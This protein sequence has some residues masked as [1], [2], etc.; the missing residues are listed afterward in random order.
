MIQKIRPIRLFIII[1]CLLT[2]KA[3]AD[4]GACC[5]NSGACY[6]TTSALVCSIHGGIWHPNLTCDDVTCETNCDGGDCSLGEVLDCNGHC[7]PISWIGDGNCDNG[8]RQWDSNTIYLDCEE[9]GY[10]GGDCSPPTDLPINPGACCIG[11]LSECDPRVCENL[12]YSSCISSNGQFLGENTAC[13]TEICS[14]P[15]GQ[16]GDCNGN[17]FPLYYLNDGICHDGHWFP[18]N[19]EDFNEYQLNL[20]CIELA[21]DYGDCTGVC[22][23][24]CCIGQNC[25]DGLPYTQCAEQGGTFLGSGETCESIDCSSY[26]ISQSVGVELIG[27]ESPIDGEFANT[28]AASDGIFI[29]ALS[30]A[31]NTNTGQPVTAA[32]VYRGNSILSQTLY[33]PVGWVSQSTCVDTD[34]ARIL[35]GQGYELRVYVDNGSTFILEQIL[36]LGSA[37]TNLSISDDVIFATTSDSNEGNGV[38]WFKRSGS[39]WIEQKP[40]LLET[41]VKN[42]VIDGDSIAL[43]TYGSLKMYS[44]DGTS[45]IE[46]D[47]DS[48]SIQ[49]NWQDVDI[50]GIYVVLGETTN[51]YNGIVAQARVFKKAEL[52]WLLDAN[53]IPV[54]TRPDDEYGYSVSIENGVACISGCF[55]DSSILNGGMIAVYKNLGGNWTYVSKAVPYNP[56]PTMGFGRAIATDG[57][58]IISTW[59]TITQD[60]W[61]FGETGSQ[62]IRLPD[63][64]WSNSDGGVIDSQ[65]NWIPSLPSEGEAVSVS[66]PARFE[67]SIPNAFPFSH[68]DIG[69]SKPTLNLTGQNLTLGVNSPGSI[70]ILGTQNYTGDLGLS[71]GDLTVNGDVLIG[72]DNRPAALSI[73]SNA[74]MTVQGSFS[75]HKNSQLQIDL[76]STDSVSLNLN[77]S[78][79]L[80][81]SLIVSAP[82]SGFDPTAGD[83]WTILESTRPLNNQKFDVIVMPGLGSDK[84]FDLEYLQ[85]GSGIQLIATVSSVEGLFDLTSSENVNVSGV[86]TDLVV[87]DIGSING[88][89]DGFDD[90]S[91]SI[92]GLPGS[93]NIFINDGTGDISSQISYPA[94][95]APSSI[96][97][98]DL[99]GDGTVDLVVTNAVD[100]TL[101]LLLNNGGAPSEMASEPT[102]SIGDYPVDV[103]ILNIDDDDDKDIVVACNG[104]E[105]ILPNGIIPGEIQFYEVMPS[106]RVSLIYAGSLSVSKPGKINPGDVNTDKDIEI[107]FTLGTAG[108]AGLA[109]RHA[110]IRGFDWEVEQLVSVGSSPSDIAVGDIDNDGDKDAIV[111]NQGANTL[112]ILLMG[113]DGQFEEEILME[114][115]DSPSSLDLLDYDSDGDLDLAVIASNDLDQRT[116]YVYRNDTSLN[117]DENITFAREQSFDDG[118]NP[119]LLGSGQLD[120]DAAE[121][122]VSILSSSGFRGFNDTAIAIK[123]ALV[124]STCSGDFDTNGVIDVADLLYVIGTWG[125]SNGDMN[126]DGTTDVL[127]ILALIAVWGPCP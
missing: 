93:V 124:I 23:G 72:Q 115:G 57:V 18:E 43:L 95:N 33:F 66:I 105:D 10:D 106:I 94:G 13:T 89:A 99:D 123:S 17:C 97:A 40:I 96:D 80:Q 36:V 38:N 35:L 102:V 92:G 26:L 86:A 114:V 3:A 48:F 56:I 59:E 62:L 73:H 91:L 120:G 27:N 111:A 31:V 1:A 88:G 85:V 82:S 9:F 21:C 44:F 122:L 30:N 32:N 78:V 65:A 121:D 108:K 12:T 75:L 54:D 34:G 98:G 103:K 60:I 37:I 84:Y 81:G 90:V 101:L 20:G 107:V 77:G 15:P 41:F 69:S 87:A 14:C 47:S 51:Y 113:I 55:N 70:D 4:D 110:G 2:G 5:Y 71:N 7:V 45:W 100:D 67:L 116:T 22:S 117:P 42:V 46:D 39:N 50:D 6:D 24:A 79:A 58:S 29:Q 8:F 109:G 118:A 127:D 11:D 74:S 52:G 19:G 126:A 16:V 104:E 68:L 112:S 49:G 25:F 76:G 64:E 125:S 53:L 61:T 63:F 119:I 28:V 83:S